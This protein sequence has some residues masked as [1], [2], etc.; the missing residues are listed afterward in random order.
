M[1]ALM[2]EL[3]DMKEQI[4]KNVESGKTNPS[5]LSGFE[6]AGRIVLKDYLASRKCAA[7]R[8]EHE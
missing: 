8:R 2:R 7:L 3:T 6:S 1:N 5:F 4:R